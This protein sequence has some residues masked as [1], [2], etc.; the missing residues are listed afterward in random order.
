[1]LYPKQQN[2]TASKSGKKN[3][4]KQPVEKDLIYISGCR[5]QKF[6]SQVSDMFCHYFWGATKDEKIYMIRKDEFGVKVK[7]I[8]Y[9]IIDPSSL[10]T[11]S[12][13]DANDIKW[14]R[15]LTKREASRLMTRFRNPFFQYD[16]L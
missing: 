15:P 5:Y 13:I 7:T 14:F 2:K 4:P 9:Y 10:M 11:I 6:Y 1:M 3:R 12:K 16:V 8:R